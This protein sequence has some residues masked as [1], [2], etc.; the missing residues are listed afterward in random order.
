MKDFKIISFDVN[1]IEHIK[2]LEDFISLASSEL[3]SNNVSRLVSR[4]LEL[5]KKDNITNV[6][7]VDKWQ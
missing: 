3:V 2:L 4:N 1:N 7:I 6:F 5:N